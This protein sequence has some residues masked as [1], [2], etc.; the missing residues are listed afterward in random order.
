[1]AFVRAER[2]TELPSISF[3]TGA[4]NCN[5]RG[6]AWSAL[7]GVQAESASGKLFKMPPNSLH[8]SRAEINRAGRTLAAPDSALSEIRKAFGVL[9]EWRNRHSLPLA[10][11][12]EITNSNLAVIQPDAVIVHRLKREPSIVAKL[13]IQPEM[14]LARM[15]DLGG[16][17]AV[18]CDR[19]RLLRIA[20]VFTAPGFQHPLVRTYD[21]VASPKSSGY[22]SL[23]L[24]HR[25]QNPSVPESHGLLVEIQLRTEIQHAWA[26]A[27]E[28][29]DAFRQSSL[30]SSR[31]PDE[32]QDF[33][34]LSGAA[35]ALLENCPVNEAFAGRS[36]EDIFAETVSQMELLLVPQKL[37]S[38]AQAVRLITGAESA[39]TCFLLELNLTSGTVAYRSF[40]ADQLEQA[41]R[42]Y[43]LSEARA[44]DSGA[45]VVLAVADSPE[46]LREAYP[47]YFMQTDRFVALLEEVK[48]RAQK[49]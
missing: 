26:T 36:P 30:K 17:R 48:L 2:K 32:W 34:R 5:G 13:R 9:G 11:L 42:E 41:N 16:L 45:I 25:Y 15:Q 49:K 22:R 44:K 28:T 33:F 46:K 3:V 18:V 4:C 29:V 23:H 31:G 19:E 43:L 12:H 8:A 40:P 24:V 14:D 10:T 39:D 1:M 47:N 7:P 35:L 27:L 38:Y 21:Y 6:M 37:R 20:G